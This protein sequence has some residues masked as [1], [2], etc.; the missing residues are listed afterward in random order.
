LDGADLLAFLIEVDAG[1]AGLGAA[2]REP[3]KVI[4]GQLQRLPSRR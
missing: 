3:P 4:I 1:V 2:Q